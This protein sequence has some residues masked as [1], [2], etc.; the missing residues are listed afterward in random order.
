MTKMSGKF[1]S[2]RNVGIGKSYL[3][4]KIRFIKIVTKLI[5]KALE[6][7]YYF[8]IIFFKK[9]N[10]SV[11]ILNVKRAFSMLKKDL[12]NLSEE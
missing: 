10:S 1:I 11:C 6:C 7:R 8:E 12:L 5:S 9:V 2:P 3:K 4:G